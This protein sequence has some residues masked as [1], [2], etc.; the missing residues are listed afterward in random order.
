ML[1]KLKTRQ[2]IG[3]FLIAYQIGID[4]SRNATISWYYEWAEWAGVGSDYETYDGP[5]IWVAIMIIHRAIIHTLAIYCFTG[6]RTFTHLYGIIEV[7]LM[8]GMIVLFVSKMIIGDWVL[9]S[10][11][12]FNTFLDLLQSPLLLVIFLPSYFIFNRQGGAFKS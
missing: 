5:M 10:F 7:I 8:I 6:N 9:F 4:F 12:F 3:V 1:Q 11:D 2:I